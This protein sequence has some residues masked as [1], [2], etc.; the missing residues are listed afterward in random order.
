MLPNKRDEGAIHKFVLD[1]KENK[2]RYD[3]RT[4]ITD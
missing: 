1:L 4:F 3:K 2:K